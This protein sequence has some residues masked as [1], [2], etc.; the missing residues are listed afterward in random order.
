VTK[1]NFS[2]NVSLHPRLCIRDE[3]WR[4]FTLLLATYIGALCLLYYRWGEWNRSGIVSG[5]QYPLFCV[6]MCS[7][8]YIISERNKCAIRYEALYSLKDARFSSPL[9]SH[10]LYLINKN[11]QEIV[12]E[13][14][15]EY[16]NR[17][18]VNKKSS[19]ELTWTSQF[20]SLIYDDNNG[21][22][23]RKL[24]FEIT[25]HDIDWPK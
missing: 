25:R 9:K 1:I 11:M 5:R 13:I 12:T 22:S 23:L 6:S 24:V 7:N 4:P 10:S 20:T 14:K 17:W 3:L 16:N 2:L 18:S 19:L 15:N 21:S 8:I